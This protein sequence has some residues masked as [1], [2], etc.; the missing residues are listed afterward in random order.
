MRAVRGGAAIWV[1]MAVGVVFMVLAV[2]FA[3]RFGDDPG[4]VA[5]PL[6]GVEAPD[7]VIPFLE[8]DGA[9]DTGSL[10]GDVV[11]MNFWASWC[12]AC[13]Q[14]HAALA[15]A[16]EAYAPLGVSF[17]GVLYQDEASQGSSFLDELERSDQFQ[18]VHDTD[19]RVG[20][21]YGVLGLP[22]T[23]FIDRN[24]IIVGKVSGPLSY[25]LL[26]ATLDSVIL[27]ETIGV[28]KT[29]EVQNR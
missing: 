1:A 7:L 6:I 4:L 24:G 13:R 21:A 23:F 8:E 20:L 11:V 18:Y 22:E 16:A 12:F 2:V 19:A 15:A 9:L 14:E 5:S 17:I 27:G 25:E 3:S 26:A 28:Q 29:G 10:S